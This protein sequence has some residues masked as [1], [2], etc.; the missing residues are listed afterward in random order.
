M[1]PPKNVLVK[2][3]GIEFNITFYSTFVDVTCCTP[4][5]GGSGNINIDIY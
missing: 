5:C 2:K 3:M 1:M 4:N